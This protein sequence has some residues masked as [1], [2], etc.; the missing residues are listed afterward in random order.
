MNEKDWNEGRNM[1]FSHADA[2]DTALLNQFLWK[3]RMGETP[4]PE[5]QHNV[6]PATQEAKSN[7]KSKEKDLD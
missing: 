5:P 2:V 6:F 4:M 7:R 3:D 1:D